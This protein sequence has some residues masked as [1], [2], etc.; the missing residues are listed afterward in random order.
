MAYNQKSKK[1]SSV[2]KAGLSFEWLQQN[3]LFLLGS[4]LMFP[5]LLAYVKKAVAQKQIDDVVINQNA[6]NQL[7]ALD[8]PSLQKSK[9]DKILVSWSPEMKNKITADVVAFC[10][11]LGVNYSWWSPKG[12]TENDE[13]AGVILAKWVLNMSAFAQLYNQVYTQ[14]RNL[15]TDFNG[16]LDEDIKARI[17]ANQI[18]KNKI[19]F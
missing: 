11:H 18:I 5:Y 1:K 15:K 7:N 2:G 10:Q 14:G 13:K 19:Y 3:W 9:V 12:W 17:R 6:S 4:F 16:L 8:N